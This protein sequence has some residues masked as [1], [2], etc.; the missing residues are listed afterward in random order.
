MENTQFL[1]NIVGGN[2]TFALKNKGE[3]IVRYRGVLNHYFRL[4]GNFFED[5]KN[6]IENLEFH[7]LVK[8]YRKIAAY[9]KSFSMEQTHH[10]VLNYLKNTNRKLDELSL[11]V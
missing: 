4:K 2:F 6:Q 7:Q 3:C 10:H 5:F 8:E 9:E 1:S 11:L